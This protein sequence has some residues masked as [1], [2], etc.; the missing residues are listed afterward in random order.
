MLRDRVTLRGLGRSGRGVVRGTVL[1]ISS[2]GF[3]AYGATT[4]V[5]LKR[6][7]IRQPS[8]SIGRR[9]GNRD[10]WNSLLL[11]VWRWVW[12]LLLSGENI[13]DAE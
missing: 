2:C 13:D 1:L 10:L 8:E 7:C 5:F 12:L 3:F 11:N 4:L 6:I 9:Y